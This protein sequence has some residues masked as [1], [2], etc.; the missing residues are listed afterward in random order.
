M[1]AGTNGILLFI[2]RDRPNVPP[3]FRIGRFRVAVLAGSCD[4]A[5]KSVHWFEDLKLGGAIAKFSPLVFS[6]RSFFVTGAS[7][8]NGW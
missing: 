1:S 6:L 7:R 8:C 3:L 4:R 2:D 5:Y